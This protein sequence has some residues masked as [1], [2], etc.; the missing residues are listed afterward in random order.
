M[1]AAPVIHR[2]TDRQIL[3]LINSRGFAVRKEVAIWIASTENYAS[4]HVGLWSGKFTREDAYTD[5][6]IPR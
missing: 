4:L 6:E 3:D 1:S 2:M 5:R